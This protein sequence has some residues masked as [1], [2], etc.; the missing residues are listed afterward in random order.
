MTRGYVLWSKAEACTTMFISVNR[1][2][3]PQNLKQLTTGSAG[4]KKTSQTDVAA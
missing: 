1:L 4:Q 2:I 3:L